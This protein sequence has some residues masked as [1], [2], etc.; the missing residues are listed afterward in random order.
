[1]FLSSIERENKLYE[2]KDYDLSSLQ[3][4]ENIGKE[5]IITA[6]GLSVKASGVA[7]VNGIIYSSL[8]EAFN[9]ITTGEVKLIEDVKISK[10]IVL[11]VDANIV[12]NLNNH[13]I[14][15]AAEAKIN[16]CLIAVPNGTT[17]TIEGCGNIYSSAPDGSDSVY[18]AIQVTTKET[19]DASKLA[20]LIINNGNISGYYYAIVGNG[21]RGNT[22]IIVNG[23][24][25]FTTSTTGVAIYNPQSNSNVIVNGGFI[26]SP[27]CVEMRSGDLTIN[28]GFLTSN[29]APTTITANGNGTTTVGS[30]IAVAQHH[31]KNPINVIVNNGVIKG[32][33]ALYQANPEKN[34]EAA[35]ALVNMNV[36]N[37]TFIAI[38]GGSM[39]VYSENKEGFIKKGSFVPSIDEKYKA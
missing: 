33:H 36:N 20:K 10:L 21:N 13:S 24:H 31:T 37:G 17:L 8:E 5:I 12:L 9:S 27:V 39:P 3:N 11:P 32:Y 23:G 4:T 30:A 15:A 22:E 7:E 35:I 34:D 29:T 26:E 38:N 2:I 19:Y 18:G 16:G 14:F 6:D 25:L 28:G 1:M